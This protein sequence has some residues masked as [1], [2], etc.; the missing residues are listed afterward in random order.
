MMKL[1][2]KKKYKIPCKNCLSTDFKYFVS[3]DSI[4]FVCLKCN[5]KGSFLKK[6]KLPVKLGD[7]CRKCDGIVIFKK[8]KFKQWKLKLPY[9][10]TGYYFCPKCKTMYMSD[11]FKVF[12]KKE[13][14]PFNFKDSKIERYPD[15]S[16][17]LVM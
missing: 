6:K 11:E 17:K 16:I 5:L 13:E 14:K 7:K 9:Y 4:E 12:N 8:A 10:Y 1:K 3:D 2:R 15:G